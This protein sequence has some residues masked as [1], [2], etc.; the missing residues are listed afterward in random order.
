MSLLVSSCSPV[1]GIGCVQQLMSMD[2]DGNSGG[3]SPKLA[4]S[5]VWGRVR[6]L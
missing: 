1:A 5:A 6:F 4:R 2:E 3:Y